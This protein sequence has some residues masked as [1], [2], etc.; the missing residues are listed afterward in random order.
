[1][2]G[3]RLFPQEGGGWGW[4][5]NPTEV[6]GRGEPEG[7]CSN[8][9]GGSHSTAG[10]ILANDTQWDNSGIGDSRECSTRYFAYFFFTSNFCG[11]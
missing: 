2:S 3:S 8:G 9:G 7:S 6:K 10:V 5:E 4:E 11:E 1:M